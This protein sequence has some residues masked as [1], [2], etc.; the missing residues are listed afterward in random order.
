MKTM[1]AAAA[2]HRIH[3]PDRQLGCAPLESPEADDQELG[4]E[5]L[6]SI[7]EDRP[8]SKLAKSARN[9]L[10]LTGHLDD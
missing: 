10:K 9:K 2:R 6:A 5:L 3:L 1:A 8:R 7:V 4:A